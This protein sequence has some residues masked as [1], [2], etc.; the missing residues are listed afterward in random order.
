[1]AQTKKTSKD[2]QTAYVEQSAASVPVLA[3]STLEAWFHEQIL[4]TLGPISGQA[5]ITA[6]RAHG[7]RHLDWMA[8]C[9]EVQGHAALAAAYQQR[10]CCQTEKA[11]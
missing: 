9:L 1:V 2:T 7:D 11:S 8:E 5:L 4:A 6:S 10:K 3:E